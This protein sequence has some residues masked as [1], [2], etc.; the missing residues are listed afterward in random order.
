MALVRINKGWEFILPYDGEFIKKHPDVVQ[1]QHL[2]WMG[3]QAKYEPGVP[4]AL[5]LGPGA[6]SEQDALPRRHIGACVHLFPLPS[7]HCWL[8]P[9]PVGTLVSELT[10]SRRLESKLGPQGE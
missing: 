2:L 9:N 5:L 4:C 7:T 10:C 6:P 1:R 8:T 3:I